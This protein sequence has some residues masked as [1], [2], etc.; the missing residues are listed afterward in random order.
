M[1][2]QDVS[3]CFV[4]TGS[5]VALLIVPFLFLSAKLT[6]RKEWPVVVLGAMV[7]GCS[8]QAVLGIFWSHL[9]QGK[10]FI[11]ALVFLGFCLVS[12]FWGY[13]SQRSSTDRG[14]TVHVQHGIFILPVI[15]LAA[16][17]VRSIHPLH[18]FALG[19]SDAY[20]H[21]HYLN[22]IVEQGFLLNVIYPSGYHW[23]LALPALVF[24][25]DPYVMA[26]FSGAFFGVGMVLAVYVFLD[27]L[28][29]RK[30]ALWASFCAACFP[31]MMILLKTGVGSFANQFGLMLIPCIL[32]A[33]GLVIQGKRKG[34]GIVFL[35][36]AGMGLAAS[37]P[38]MLCHIFIIIGIERIISLFYDRKKWGIRTLLVFAVCLPSILLVI[39]HFSQAGGGQ[40]FETAKTLIGNGGQS[41]VVKEKIVQKVETAEYLIANFHEKTIQIVTKS[42]YF[43]LVI[44]FLLIKRVG[45]GNV[46]LNATAI[47][48]FL[49]FLCCVGY[50]IY[51]KQQGILILGV[52]GALTTIQATIGFFQFSY[53]QREGWSLLIATS[54][55]VGVLVAVFCLYLGR[56]LI[57]KAGLVVAL[58]LSLYFTVTHPPSHPAIQS[59]AEDLLIRTVRF[60]DSRNKWA[61]KDCADSIDSL[62]TLLESLDKS[63]P[64]TLVSRK[65][66][67]WQNHQGEL[68]PN[69][70]SLDK[71]VKTILVSSGNKRI[72]ISLSKD[73]QYV[74]FV[75]KIEKISP[76]NVVS[77]FAM[78]SPNIVHRVLQQQR[79]LYRANSYILDYINTLDTKK[80][81]IKRVQM[82]KNLDVYTIIP[83]N[84]ISVNQE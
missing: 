57:V 20:S 22:N 7:L 44:D 58:A 9:V 46:Y 68:I 28:V 33:Y 42:P 59:S 73:S 30:S 53:Y 84:A 77:A 52:W 8:L 10:P 75:D 37:V 23:L 41:E 82:S 17:W 32:L 12:T 76:R 36:V 4:V 43:N 5:L 48:L 64:L 25:I 60:V 63:L 81:K 62:C 11:E 19:Q 38:M 15:L 13:S 72:N 70:L 56:F 47:I 45:F 71:T 35:L 66:V 29:G 1:T 50:G 16:F 18:T 31:G 21:L 67:G 65:F 39:F 2:I 27:T 26:R 3:Q 54:C 79:C 14:T 61:D 80:W 34:L 40:R 49:L 51:R 24:K 55:L 69:V 6:K 74:V 83:A 78:V